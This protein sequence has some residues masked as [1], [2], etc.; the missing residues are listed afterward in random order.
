VLVLWLAAGVLG[1][2]SEAPPVVE[3]GWPLNAGASAPVADKQEP[4]KLKHTDVYW[5]LRPKATEAPTQIE[6]PQDNRSPEPKAASVA[7]IRSL[8]ALQ[9]AS[10]AEQDNSAAM[11]AT[12]AQTERE[13]REAQNA[14]DLELAAVALLLAA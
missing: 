8:S 11:V 2:P 4:R 10:V 3:E 14:T 13:A 5:P 12:Q 1:Q 9:I 7:P 6:L